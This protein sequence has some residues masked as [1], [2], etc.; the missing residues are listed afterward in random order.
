MADDKTPPELVIAPAPIKRQVFLNFAHSSTRARYV[1]DLQPG[2]SLVLRTTLTPRP[3]P[4]QLPVQVLM[5]DD[6]EPG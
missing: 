1:G 3:N 4:L 5:E 2:E 6:G